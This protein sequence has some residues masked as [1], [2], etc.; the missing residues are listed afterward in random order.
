MVDQC[1]LILANEL[2]KSWKLKTTELCKV[3]EVWQMDRSLQ[4]VSDGFRFWFCRR[5]FVELSPCFE[6]W[7]HFSPTAGPVLV[8]TCSLK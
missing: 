6:I 4:M 8:L 7:K 2:S 1:W 3:G 5:C